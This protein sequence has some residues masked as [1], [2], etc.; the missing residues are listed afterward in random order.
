MNRSRVFLMGMLVCF[1]LTLV[2]TALVYR[3]LPETVPTHWNHRGEI[4]GYGKKGS[5][6]ILPVMQFPMAALFLGLSYGIGQN[7]RERSSF[8]LLG[9]LMTAF[10]LC[11]QCLILA[12]SLKLRVDM[13]RWMGSLLSLMFLG[14]GFV[15]KDLPRNGL[16][17]IRLPW[18]MASDEAWKISH[19]RA[20]R[21]V[22][23]GSALGLFLS[24]TGLGMAG[25]ICSVGALLYTC[26]DS[27]F[28]T[29]RIRTA[30]SS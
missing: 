28:A 25:I 24:L 19:E 7:D 18:T 9:L 15:L 16:A 27:Y 10:F 20:S 13:N 2:V 1:V 5:V 17:G 23:A 4:D 11:L 6:W 21:I 22:M 3:Q 29:R 12:S 14:I 30:N 26:I 8:L